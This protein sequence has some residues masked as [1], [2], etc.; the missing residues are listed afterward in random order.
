MNDDAPSAGRS[1]RAR[2][3]LSFDPARLKADLDGLGNVEWTPHFVTQH[4]EGDW[5]VIALRGPAGATHPVMMIYS[6]PGCTD[7]ADTPFLAASPYFQS[8]MRAFRCKLLAVRLMKLAAGARILEHADHDLDIESGVV[9]LHIPVVTNPDVHFRLNGVRT[10]LAEG[11]CWYLRLS[12][13]HT[14]ENRGDTHRVHLVIDAQVN[15][16]LLAQFPPA[17]REHFGNAPAE[18]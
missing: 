12:D 10:I 3:P 7:F 8:V 5:C 1:D 2:L 11:E 14:V 13:P 15:A 9:R 16:W 6:D 4:Y 17:F 18:G